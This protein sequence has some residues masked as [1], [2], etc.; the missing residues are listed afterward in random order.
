M[1]ASRTVRMSCR[2]MR[3]KYLWY[4]LGGAFTLMS[5]CGCQSESSN[6]SA[7]T[8]TSDAQTTGSVSPSG[9]TAV[10][11]APAP[12][13]LACVALPS[14]PSDSAEGPPAPRMMAP[15]TTAS[16]DP[17][18]VPAMSSATDIGGAPGTGGSAGHGGTGNPVDVGGAS[19]A[20]DAPGAGGAAAPR[21]LVDAAA[22]PSDS[23]QPS[24]A[25][26]EPA[27]DVFDG[28]AE[29]TLTA[30]GFP[31]LADGRLTFPDSAIYP[32]DV[33]PPFTWSGV[34]GDTQSLALVFRD[35]GIG[36]VKWIIW[37]VSPET[38]ELPAGVSDD[39]MPSEVP[40]ASQLGSIGNQGYSGPQ[41]PD[42]DY[43]FTL[44]ALDVASLPGTSGLSTVQIFNQLIL[45]HEIAQT[46]A[47]ELHTDPGLSVR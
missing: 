16:G 15:V 8:N 27:S 34:P 12:G 20:D 47:V 1:I 35:L 6:P 44:Y 2:P 29:F 45:V 21:E 23:T 39:A 17:P 26:T 38:M 11:S 31:T 46:A 19:V 36:A 30:V 13:P 3:S 28:G 42:E 24:S 5:C 41:N 40:G 22:F 33:S 4:V 14:F 43:D 7:S 37:D 18:L 9:V 32:T 25:N 10:E